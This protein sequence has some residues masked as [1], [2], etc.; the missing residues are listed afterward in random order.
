MVLELL[1]H[2]R[3]AEY[4]FGYNGILIDH[5]LHKLNISNDTNMSNC[6]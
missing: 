4:R 2:Y 5:K 1:E 6:L 3:A